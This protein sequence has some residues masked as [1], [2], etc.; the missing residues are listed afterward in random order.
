[1]TAGGIEWHAMVS[2]DGERLVASGRMKNG[3]D[4]ATKGKWMNKKRVCNVQCTS[5]RPL[6]VRTLTVLS[7]PLPASCR[8]F[9]SPSQQAR[10][11]SAMLPS[12][13]LPS[14]VAG[15]WPETKM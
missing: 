9:L 6:D 5:I 10:V 7:I 12:T 1:M 11:L 14:A 13:S 15:I 2:R 4:G 8:M 3:Q